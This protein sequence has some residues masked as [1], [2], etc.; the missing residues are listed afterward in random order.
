MDN[1]RVKI[2]NVEVLSDN[3]Y[4]LNKVT[5]DYLRNDG[6]WQTQIRESYD[7]GNGATVFMYNKE[8]QNIVLIKQ[9]RFP[10]FANGNED[11]LLIET[12]AGLLD[13]DDP[14][15]CIKK[16]I[17]E[18]TGYKIQTVKKVFEAYM[19]PGAVTEQMHYF[20][21]EYSDD[22]KANNGG[23]LDSEQEDIEVLEMAFSVAIE[24]MNNG[25][26][27]DAKTILLLQYAI[28]HKLLE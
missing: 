19:T 14:E 22:M 11:G 5:F 27:K 13:E 16:E 3:W 2:K 9:F 28:I 18:E 4:T 7:R 10:S 1:K 23:G 6:I 24:L 21:A 25:T 12:C 26:I 20:I 8:T 15:T 17:F